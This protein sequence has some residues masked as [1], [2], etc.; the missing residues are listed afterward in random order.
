MKLYRKIIPKV[1]K[2]IVR[3]LL[4]Q[5]A[6]EIEDG[7]RDEAELDIAGSLVDY[8]NSVDQIKSDA[9]EA[10]VRHN[11]QHDQ[12]FR[13]QRTLAE[14]RKIVIGELALDFVIDKLVQSLFKSKHISEIFAEDVDLRLTVT[15]S[16]R[17]YLGV[18]ESI[19]REVRSRI[20]HLREGTPE[21]ETEYEK[22][23]GDLRQAR[24]S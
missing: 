23:V 4:S 12:L 16:L 6:I 9:Q 8:L 1:A 22:W 13:I 7:H 3:S 10:L 5:E 14:N 11:L 19:D 15:T 2:D 20:K 18:D 24:V 21:W 17:K